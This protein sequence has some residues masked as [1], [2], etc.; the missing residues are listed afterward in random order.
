[1]SSQAPR[2]L[3]VQGTVAA[4]RDI[5]YR[6]RD[7]GY[8]I[9]DSGFGIRDSGFGIRDRIRD[10]DDEHLA[11]FGISEENRSIIERGQIDD[12]RCVK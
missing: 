3:Q 10:P 6:I 2:I 11:F 5:F 12:T 8:G 1:M 9:Q 4:C 7:S